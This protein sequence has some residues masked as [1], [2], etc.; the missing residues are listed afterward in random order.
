MDRHQIFSSPSAKGRTTVNLFHQ[1]MLYFRRAAK[2]H[3]LLARTV[4]VYVFFLFILFAALAL[5]RYYLS[6]NGNPLDGF[7]VSVIDNLSAGIITAGVAAVLL[8]LV[9]PRISLDEN[10]AVLDA[11]NINPALNKPLATTRLYYFRGRS[12]RWVRTQVLPTLVAAATRESVQRVVHMILPNPADTDVLRTYADY[13]NSLPHNPGD[14]W[15]PERI[16]NE[17]LA[18][19][20][21]A[22][23]LASGSMFF[24]AHVTLLNDFSLFRADLTDEALVLTREDPRMP[25]W[26]STSSSKF[27]ASY[28]EDLRMAERRGLPIQFS[29]YAYP[30]EFKAADVESALRAMGIAVALHEAERTEVLNAMSGTKSSYV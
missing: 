26:F 12:G 22:G 25:G 24:E 5:A 15:T 6:K 29:A 16:R 21:E 9:S 8:F 28:L 11:W 17:I 27:Y 23:R 20:L 3:Q 1:L 13:R 7:P 18:T 14:V 4:T 2:P 30:A 10:L 19:I